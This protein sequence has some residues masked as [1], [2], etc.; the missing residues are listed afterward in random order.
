M[1]LRKV[2]PHESK[3]AP[4]PHAL[5]R[6]RGFEETGN[7]QPLSDGPALRVAEMELML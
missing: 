5:Y 6:R 4:G 3:D 7:E 1:H 2:G